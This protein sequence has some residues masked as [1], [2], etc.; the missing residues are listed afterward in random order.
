VCIA[1]RWC[2]LIRTLR[3]GAR[4]DPHVRILC[5]RLL[6]TQV[7]SY[8]APGQRLFDTQVN[9]YWAPGQRLLGTQVNALLEPTARPGGGGTG[10]AQK[11]VGP[12]T[13]LRVVKRFPMCLRERTRDGLAR[14]WPLETEAVVVVPNAAAATPAMHEAASTPHNIKCFKSSA[15]CCK[16]SGAWIFG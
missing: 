10:P 9:G 1:R 2:G 13:K 11:A 8:W 15:K 12:L 3:P 14:W 5:R 7:N 16:C 4:T 6:G